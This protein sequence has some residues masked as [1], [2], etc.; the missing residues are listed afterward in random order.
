MYIVSTDAISSLNVF[1]LQL[2]ESVDIET[3]AMEGI[4]ILF[5]NMFLFVW[6]LFIEAMLSLSLSEYY[7]V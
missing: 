3:T 4:A 7:V 1:N 2:V 6:I 5:P